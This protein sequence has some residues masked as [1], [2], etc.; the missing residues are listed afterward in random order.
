MGMKNFANFTRVN[1]N[2]CKVRD[3][4]FQ[5]AALGNRDT[6]EVNLEG[7][8]L[9]DM[10][11]YSVR[12]LKLTQYSLNSIASEYLGEQKEDVYPGQ[13]SLLQKKSE[14]T[15]RRLA[16]YCIK[17]AYLPLRIIQKL[18]CITSMAEISRVC[19]VPF[20]YLFTRGQN[21]KVSSLLYRKAQELG[22]LIP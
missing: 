13:I 14:W 9:L 2:L 7:R 19:G 6:K 3:T 5:S 18:D 1:N 15:R 4:T 12:E 8:I 16:I 17:D 21:V 11:T 10:F 22:F 20:A